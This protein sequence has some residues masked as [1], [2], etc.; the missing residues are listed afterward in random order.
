MRDFDGEDDPPVPDVVEDVHITI[1]LLLT[2]SFTDQTVD[3][4]QN[5]NPNFYFIYS[6]NVSCADTYLLL[7]TWLWG[8]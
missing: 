4:G 3:K 5:E 8:Y 6:Y 7:S 2:S 1:P